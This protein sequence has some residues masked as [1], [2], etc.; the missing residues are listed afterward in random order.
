MGRGQIEPLEKSTA[1]WS[2]KQSVF[3][4]FI[5]MGSWNCDKTNQVEKFRGTKLQKKISLNLAGKK[6]KQNDRRSKRGKD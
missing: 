4:L 1:M 3:Q 6:K 2:G 5:F